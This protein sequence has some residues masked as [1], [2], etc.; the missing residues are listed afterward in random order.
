MGA[1]IWEQLSTSFKFS[2]VVLI[3]LLCVALVIGVIKGW[4]EL[5]KLLNLETRREREKREYEET[6][7][8]LNSKITAA[9]DRSSKL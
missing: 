4:Q 2:D 6:I 9:D 3:L 5:L 1:N 7:E 8:E